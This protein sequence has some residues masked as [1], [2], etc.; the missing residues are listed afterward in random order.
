MDKVLPLLMAG[1]IMLS[2]CASTT[3]TS[4]RPVSSVKPAVALSQ[5]EQWHMM[6]GKWYGEQP[7][8]EGGIRKWLVE[9]FINGTYRIDFRISKEDGTVDVLAEVG[10]WG[11][12]GPVYF[13]SFRG[14]VH[15][16]RIERSDRSD[17]YNYDAYRILQLSDTVFEYQHY[18]TG[19]H[20][21]V[22]KVAPDFR[23]N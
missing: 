1:L 12:S 6:V 14:W 13:S 4:S 17:P 2:G 15:G 9:R 11:I 19:N 5:E 8:K 21:L 7:T 3:Q 23:F 20:F 10:E 18:S 16:E 22:R